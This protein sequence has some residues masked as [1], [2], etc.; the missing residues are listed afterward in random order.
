MLCSK[1]YWKFF[2]FG[3]DGILQNENRNICFAKL[4]NVWPKNS[5]TLTQSKVDFLLSEIFSVWPSADLL[6]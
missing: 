5:M 4:P 2:L 3:T 6:T 1:K